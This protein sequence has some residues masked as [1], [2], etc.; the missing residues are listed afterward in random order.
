MPW[1]YPKNLE[2][3]ILPVPEFLADRHTKRLIYRVGHKNDPSDY[4]VY[5][6]SARVHLYKQYSI[7]IVVSFYTRRNQTLTTLLKFYTK[8]L[9]YNRSTPAAF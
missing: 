2:T 5:T 1:S 7:L 8:M 9:R 3:I 6:V 4:A